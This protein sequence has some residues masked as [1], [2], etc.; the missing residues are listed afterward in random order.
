VLDNVRVLGFVDNVDEYLCASD[1]AI[2][3]ITY[4]SGTRIKVLDAWAAGVPVIS[5]SAA[6]SGLDYETNV[7]VIIEG[8]GYGEFY[9]LNLAMINPA[10]TGF[11]LPMSHQTWILFPFIISLI[12]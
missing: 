10:P 5:T 8:N 6:I 11:L 1:I 12:Y 7:N 4:G 9:L 2:V 3:P